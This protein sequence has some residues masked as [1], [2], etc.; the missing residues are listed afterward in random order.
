VGRETLSTSPGSGIVSVLAGGPNCAS[1]GAPGHI[2]ICV[3]PGD[4]CQPSF[5][6]HKPP[7]ADK[8]QSAK[9]KGFITTTA[10][11]IDVLPGQLLFDLL[12]CA[13]Q[14]S[15]ARLPPPG[16]SQPIGIYFSFVLNIRSSYFVS[17]PSVALLHCGRKDRSGQCH[18]NQESKQTWRTRKNPRARVPSQEEAASSQ[19][20][21]KH[22]LASQTLV[23]P[24][25]QEEAFAELES[26]LRADLLP[27]G[28]F[29]EVLFHNI[30]GASWNMRRCELAELEL[31]EKS[32]DINPLL[33]PTNEATLR[34][35]RLYFSRAERSFHKFVKE[36]RSI[37]TDRHQRCQ[38]A[39]PS[40]ADSDAATPESALLEIL[41]RLVDDKNGDAATRYRDLMATLQSFPQS[42][43][44][45]VSE[46]APS[47]F[48]DLLP[49]ESA[50]AS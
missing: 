22:G 43:D 34:N 42:S 31:A 46:P 25:G 2:G 35:V 29:G 26:G 39:A 49:G 48:L 36:L 13:S 20:A 37:Q 45:D 15:Q 3:C 50:P 23:I 17:V 27:E 24:P 16:A 30:L 21:R 11:S 4:G 6:A 12:V 28:T 32:P 18:Q 38:A 7:D 5:W 10:Y 40:A 9:S 41:N 8:T 44:P 19:N 33:D 47:L 14:E 1:G